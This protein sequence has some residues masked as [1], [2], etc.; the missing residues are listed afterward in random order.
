MV[1]LLHISCS[2]KIRYDQELMESKL[3]EIDEKLMKEDENSVH[4]NSGHCFCLFD[5]PNTCVEVLNIFG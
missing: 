3:K 5:V 4:A 1:T 2:K